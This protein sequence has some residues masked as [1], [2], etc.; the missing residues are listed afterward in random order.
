M[1]HRPC[2]RTLAMPLE[3]VIVLEPE[4]VERDEASEHK[5]NPDPV[6]QGSVWRCRYAA[7]AR[8]GKGTDAQWL[9]GALVAA[10][11]EHARAALRRWVAED[12]A[13]RTWGAADRILADMG[14]P[15]RV[16]VD[17][18]R[19]AP[20]EKP[21]RPAL[22]PRWARRHGPRCA[23]VACDMKRTPAA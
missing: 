7:M 13:R 3:G 19:G 11:G 20:P 6:V 5:P 2:K 14:I 22:G 16:Q 1:M 18:E 12:G 17:L 23:C 21:R 10:H 8:K 15:D 9:A 4:D